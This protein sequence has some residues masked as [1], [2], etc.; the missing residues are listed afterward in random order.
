MILAGT[1]VE[2]LKFNSPANFGAVSDLAEAVF[3]PSGGGAVFQ[4][5]PA[6]LMSGGSQGTW[7]YNAEWHIPQIG[8][9]TAGSGNDIIAFLPG[10]SRTVCEQVNDEFAIT[11]SNCTLEG[12]VPELG[13]RCG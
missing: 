2:N 3:H 10:V 1:D 9:D 12:V 11:T 8:V 7:F 13:F 4:R 6:E 5:A